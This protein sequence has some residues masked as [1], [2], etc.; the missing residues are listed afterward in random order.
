MGYGIVRDR[1]FGDGNFPA[2]GDPASLQRAVERKMVSLGG[3][4]FAGAVDSAA[5]NGAD[6]PDRNLSTDCHWENQPDGGAH[7]E[8]IK[9]LTRD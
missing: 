1:A 4:N 6:V 8:P 3:P 9:I 2:D 5:R 7:G